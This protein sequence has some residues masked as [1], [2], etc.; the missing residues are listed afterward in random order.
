MKSASNRPTMTPTIASQQ[1]LR[2]RRSS[3]AIAVDRLRQAGGVNSF[4]NFARSWQRAAGFAEVAP[5]RQ[6]FRYADED[7][8]DDE[9]EGV[10][11]GFDRA[12]VQT[13][14][15]SRRSLLR[16][17]LEEERGEGGEGADDVHDDNIFAI[18]PSLASPFGG[19][20]GTT[21]GSLSSR[22][23]EPSI[24]HAARLYR[25][26]QSK[27][28]ASPDRSRE[29]LLVK[30]VADEDGKLVNVVVGQST[31]PQTIFNSVNVLIG[32]GLLALPLAL[33]L[34]GW[35]PGLIFSIFAAT[36]T[37]YTAKLLAKC[38]DVDNSLITFADLAYVS[39]GPWA[40]V[41]TSV[42]FSLEL[43]GACVA[44]VVLF[45]DS[46]DALVPGWGVT[47][48]KIVCGLILVPLGFVPL[49]WLS[50]TSILGIFCC[51]G[52]VLAVLV[53][54]LLK[55]DAPG[56]LRQPAETYWFPANWMTLPIAFGILMSPW[57][58]HSVFPNIYRDMRHP[59]RYRR[60]VNITF[61]VTSTLDLF[62]AVIGLLMYGDGVADEI[63]RN[64][65]DSDATPHAIR[66]FLV[67]CV[68]IIPIT[69]VPLNARPIVS[70]LELF[71]GLDPR[72]LAASPALTGL[73]GSARGILKILV[74]VGTMAGFVV[75]AVLVPSFDTIMS[76]LGATA[77]FTVCII[78]PCAFHLKLFGEHLSRGRK[79]LDWALIVVSVALAG[80]ST[81]F[82]FVP[83]EKMGL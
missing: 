60:S 65:L 49:R 59:F 53:E 30:Q 21:W 33:R 20:Y 12:T 56:S 39:F 48:W 42:L 66:I 47:E 7:D 36:S 26:Q 64:L 13:S 6:S 71:L 31:L 80:V 18:E 28:T 68:A 58:G 52:I 57:G 9:E 34:A 35:I 77:C 72:A 81:G 41:G 44:L 32:V 45:A 14:P 79:A 55:A 4:D 73:T 2:R 8:E 16:A 46:L 67:I 3:V 37:C 78:L 54:G 11:D 83:R 17:A 38:L 76:L 23:T 40:R 63:T 62:M 51:A 74:R 29:P 19:S 5:V 27:G 25:R 22:V 1:D 61:A 82:N 15:K 50:F 24:R 69:K 70:T 43:I 10:G 75:L